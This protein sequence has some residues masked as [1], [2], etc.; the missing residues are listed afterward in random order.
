MHQPEQVI[1]SNM[2]MIESDGNV[3]VQ[4]RV[5]PHWPGV[6]F[7]GGHVE[8]GETFSQA[9]IR[10]IREETGLTIRNPRLCGVK[11]WHDHGVRHMVLLYKTSEYEG[12]LAS[13]EEGRVWWMPLKD[14]PSAPLASGMATMLRLFL[15]EDLSEY[16][17]LVQGD[18]W[19]DVLE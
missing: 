4:E 13:S 1:F 6:V 2:C 12:E 17:F 11:H 7:P 14:F 10:E 5:D 8:K 3:V 16:S 18:E 9:V 15:E 19:V